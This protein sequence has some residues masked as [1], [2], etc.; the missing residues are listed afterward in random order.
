M[1]RTLHA[2][3]IAAALVCGLAPGAWA[4]TGMLKGKVVDGED[5]PVV[6]A[7]V[8][9]EG[10]ESASEA[11][12]AIEAGADHLQGYY[13]APPSASLPDEVL[14]RRILAELLRMSGMHLQPVA[15]T[16]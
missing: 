16:G 7:Q 14:N 2:S 11:L 3:V 5:K 9:I 13:F 4:Q 1:F 10:V 15:R 12:V 8:T 6:G